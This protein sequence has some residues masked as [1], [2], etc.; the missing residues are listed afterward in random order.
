MSN[1]STPC[2]ANR[3]DDVLATKTPN[4]SYFRAISTRINAEV[5]RMHQA[6]NEDK[7]LTNYKYSP[8]EPSSREECATTQITTRELSNC[9]L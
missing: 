4:L 6:V 2:K 5:H 8:R 9:Y 7:N 3:E 1:F